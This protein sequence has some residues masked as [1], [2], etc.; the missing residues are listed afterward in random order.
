MER[1]PLGRHARQVLVPDQRGFLPAVT[2]TIIAGARSGRA[3]LG[4]A[5]GAGT[6]KEVWSFVTWVAYACYLHARATAGWKGRKA[7]Y[8]ALFAFA[9]WIWN[10]YGV[11]HPAQ[12]QA[13]VRG[14]LTG[15]SGT[16][17]S[18]LL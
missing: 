14:R 9:C 11:K 3:T 16:L 17:V 18:C 7:A 2:F 4:A 10:Y 6:P 12:R 15:G 5:T 13:L 8:L 1:L